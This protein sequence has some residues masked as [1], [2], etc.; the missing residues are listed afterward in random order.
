MFELFRDIQYDPTVGA[1]ATGDLFLPKDRGSSPAVLLIHGGGWCSMDRHR[2]EGVA[3]WLVELGCAVLNIDYRLIPGAP[4][5]ACERDCI[6]AGW[7]LLNADFPGE[8]RLDRSAIAIIGASAGA[9]LALMAGLKLPRERVRGIVDISGPTDL[10]TEDMQR[11]RDN[12]Q[13]CGGHD[14]PGALL[15]AASPVNHVAADPPPLL[16]L[17]AHNDTVV[18]SVQADHIYTAWRKAAGPVQAYIYTGKTS[19]HHIW[20]ADGPSDPPVLGSRLTQQIHAFL[21]DHA[22]VSPIDAFL[23]D[24][25]GVSPIDLVD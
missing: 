13:F 23:A 18:S 14:D 21:A 2:M 5:P 25:A 1:S 12:A 9:H 8:A 3:Q 11:L 10:C 24:H 16:I 22:G 7:F 6:A 17:H 15:H 19:G 4:Y 20:S